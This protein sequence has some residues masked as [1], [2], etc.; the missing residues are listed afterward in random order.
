MKIKKVVSKKE[1]PKR[2]RELVYTKDNCTGC[3]MCAEVCPVDAIGLGPTGAIARGVLDAPYIHVNEN[4]ITCGTCTK[5][6]MFDALATHTNGIKDK[7]ENIGKSIAGTNCNA[8]NLCVEVCPRDCV[9]VKRIIPPISSYAGGEFKMKMDRCIYCGICEDICPAGAITVERGGLSTKHRIESTES[10]ARFERIEL[11]ES[12]CIMC[13]ICARACPTDTLSVIKK[14]DHESKIEIKGEIAINEDECTWCGW[15]DVACPLDNIKIE[16]PFEGTIEIMEDVCEGCGAC[17]EICPCD[18]LY[19]PLTQYP[20]I[21]THYDYTKGWDKPLTTRPAPTAKKL[22]VHK[23]RCVSCGAC[24]RT[25]PVNAIN[26]T[27]DK[28]RFAE[29]LPKSVQ[30]VFK[31]VLGTVEK[32]EEPKLVEIVPE[33]GA[34]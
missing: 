2:V 27:R 9:E 3:G 24:V 26:V 18:A 20:D 15:C 34:S 10:P 33:V 13:G 30:N 28:L 14:G 29:D 22:D 5:V 11:D 17:V 21:K 19:F 7:T 25:C 31:K 1:T 4:C 8:C 12:K 6:C 16:K 23:E 32:I